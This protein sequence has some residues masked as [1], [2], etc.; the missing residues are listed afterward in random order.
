M[1]PRNWN[2]STRA[3]IHRIATEAK[4]RQQ[5]IACVIHS[6]QLWVPTGVFLAICYDKRFL[7]RVLRPPT[8]CGQRVKRHG[9]PE[10]RCMY[11]AALYWFSMV[12]RQQTS[13]SRAVY[14][15]VPGRTGR[16]GNWRSRAGCGKWNV[17]S[18]LSRKLLA[19]SSAKRSAADRQL[20]YSNPRQIKRRS[21]LLVRVYAACTTPSR[22]ETICTP[23]LQ[24]DL[25]WQR[26]G[27]G[28]EK[29]RAS[30]A[31]QGD[32]ILPML[33]AT[34]VVFVCRAQRKKSLRDD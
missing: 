34:C 22:N 5:V 7:A 29:T 26:Y 21:P 2:A 6:N 12:H 18:I 8:K 10:M 30:G 33:N 19:V 15:R 28:G 25:Y 27:D 14:N 24:R 32:V 11:T 13:R 23:R 31:D 4:P 3:L 17:H 1:S 9:R 20:Q 16:G